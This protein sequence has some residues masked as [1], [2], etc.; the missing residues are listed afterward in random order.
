VPS[1]LASAH[2]ELAIF[3]LLMYVFFCLLVQVQG[4]ID[5]ACNNCKFLGIRSDKY[6][7]EKI[8]IYIS[9]KLQGHTTDVHHANSKM[10]VP[11]DD[12]SVKLTPG[13]HPCKSQL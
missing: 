8:Y 1:F 2:P 3:L 9:G 4:F 12:Q 10:I 6:T 5:C 11:V 13:D 7:S